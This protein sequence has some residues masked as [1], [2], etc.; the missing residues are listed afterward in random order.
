MCDTVVWVMRYWLNAL[1]LG[2]SVAFKAIGA[3]SSSFCSVAEAQ[4]TINCVAATCVESNAMIV[5]EMA[6]LSTP[7]SVQFAIKITSDM[8]TFTGRRASSAKRLLQF[9]QGI[10]R[11]DEHGEDTKE[12]WRIFCS[13]E[14]N[15]DYPT[16]FHAMQYLGSYLTWMQ[17]YQKNAARVDEFLRSVTVGSADWHKRLI[18]VRLG[19]ITKSPLSC[20]DDSSSRKIPNRLDCLVG[21]AGG[22]QVIPLDVCFRFSEILRRDL[23]S[24]ICVQQVTGKVKKSKRCR[25][26]TL[27][28]SGN[29]TMGPPMFENHGKNSVYVACRDWDWLKNGI[30][31]ATQTADGLNR[32]H[33]IRDLVW[34]TLCIG[35]DP[36]SPD[37]S[38]IS[39][40]EVMPVASA[41]FMGFSVVTG[42]LK[43]S[44]TRLSDARKVLVSSTIEFHHTLPRPP[45]RCSPHSVDY[46]KADIFDSEL[47]LILFT[48]K[49]IWK[50]YD[51]LD[52][53]TPKSR[54]YE[55]A[56]SNSTFHDTV[57][58]FKDRVNA[59]CQN[60]VSSN[61]T[62]TYPYIVNVRHSDKSV[63]LLDEISGQSCHLA[64]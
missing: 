50:H 20:D 51:N 42:T 18:D 27:K 29:M 15:D 40:L 54:R 14:P 12:L 9:A 36:E 30:E 11:D 31:Q 61:C 58:T 4:I 55:G 38:T 5:R 28:C 34:P 26:G 17:E 63:E 64:R 39:Q 7:E 2:D 59:D 43:S 33:K 49:H 44:S 6:G 46:T 62:C 32:C 21:G 52:Y 23:K 56:I 45:G 3:R 35:F 60:F 48:L 13:F 53:P 10:R 1:R 22:A 41:I 24:E 19:T 8:V 25:P 57:T 37:I 16:E 47:N